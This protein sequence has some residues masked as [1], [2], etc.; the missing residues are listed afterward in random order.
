[1]CTCIVPYTHPRSKNRFTQDIACVKDIFKL[2]AQLDLYKLSIEKVFRFLFL[3]T[4]EKAFNDT[5]WLKED[6]QKSCLKTKKGYYDL[7]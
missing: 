4:P 6:T 5:T 1:M 2:H 7:H 3:L